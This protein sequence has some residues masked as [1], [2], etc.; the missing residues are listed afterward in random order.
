MEGEE[1]LKDSRGAREPVLKL[2]IQSPT[3]V[4][5]PDG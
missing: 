1:M 5:D 4:A 3:G 2:R